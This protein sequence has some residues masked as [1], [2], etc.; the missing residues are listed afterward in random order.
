MGIINEMFSGDSD[1]VA[2][3]AMEEELS[4]TL[5]QDLREQ[6]GY[7][8]GKYGKIAHWERNRAVRGAVN[9]A[10]FLIYQA[11]NTSNSLDRKVLEETIVESENDNPVKVVMS[12]DTINIPL[13]RSLTIEIEGIEDPLILREGQERAR[14]GGRSNRIA[15]SKQL[16]QHLNL[17]GLVREKLEPTTSHQ[18]QA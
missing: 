6:T 17:I 5:S 15:S 18:T 9:I 2:Q 3:A 14:I 13:A 4:R 11:I 1:E 12:S 7:L 16:L 10:G 8:I